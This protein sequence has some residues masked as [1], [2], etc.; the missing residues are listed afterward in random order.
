VQAV[1]SE[2]I[3]GKVFWETPPVSPA[4]FE[5]KLTSER[6]TRWKGNDITHS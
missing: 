1:D 5:R 3:F 4:L 2:L 6:Q